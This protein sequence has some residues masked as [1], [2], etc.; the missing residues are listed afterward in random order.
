MKKIQEGYYKGD[1]L[2]ELD[3]QYYIIIS[4][5]IATAG[6]MLFSKLKLGFAKYYPIESALTLDSVNDV[7]GQIKR[8]MAP[9]VY[10]K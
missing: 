1:F 2:I 6:I 4:E 3:D 5:G 7:I 8:D 9:R 10:L